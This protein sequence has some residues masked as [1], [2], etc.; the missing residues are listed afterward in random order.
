MYTHT[1]TTIS[2]E[3]LRKRLVSSAMSDE[4]ALRLACEPEG[5]KAMP[6]LSKK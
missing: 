1:S 4:V 6:P 5:G 2:Y 3:A